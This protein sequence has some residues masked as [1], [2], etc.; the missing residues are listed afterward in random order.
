M[1]L[2]YQRIE[3]PQSEIF[4]LL[5]FVNFEVSISKF[6]DQWISQFSAGLVSDP[7]PDLDEIRVVW[8]SPL[9][10]DRSV[11]LGR[12]QSLRKRGNKIFIKPVSRTGK[13]SQKR[14]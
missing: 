3:I 4:F 2:S 9:E 6:R 7:L 8:W 5:N 13:R 11:H 1:T 10:Q 14:Q 12:V